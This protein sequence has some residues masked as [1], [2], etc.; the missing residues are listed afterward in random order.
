MF[1]SKTGASSSAATPNRLGSNYNHA[2]R[3]SNANNNQN[4][5]RKYTSPDSS[6]GMT[7]TTS[8]PDKI[9]CKN[10]NHTANKKDQHIGI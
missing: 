9:Q 2:N 4:T 8:M 10:T 5:K 7:D 1:A 6:D 3:G